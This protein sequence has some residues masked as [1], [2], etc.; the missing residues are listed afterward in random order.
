MRTRRYVTL[1]ALLAA[2]CFCAHAETVR[3]DFAGT[4]SSAVMGSLVDGESFTASISIDV[5]K[6]TQSMSGDNSL[7]SFTLPSDPIAGVASIS[8]ASGLTRSFGLGLRP[9]VSGITVTRGDVGN[10]YMFAVGDRP[11]L[12]GATQPTS[13]LGLSVVDFLGSGSRI[14]SAPPADLGLSQDVDWLAAG[15][16]TADSTF[17]DD[18]D[19]QYALLV[20][21]SAQRVTVPVP[22][23]EPATYALMIAGLAAVA[24][25][26]RGRRKPATTV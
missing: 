22:I 6:L 13:F 16:S 11:T 5:S 12:P 14:F 19:G 25:T 3:Y 8:F 21:D 9:S 17:Y 24:L 26:A 2:T 4:V 7:A 18:L 10:L 20:I 1:S 23:P 15:S